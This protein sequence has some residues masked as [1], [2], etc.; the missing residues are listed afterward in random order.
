MD[1]FDPSQLDST[2]KPTQIHDFNP[3]TIDS[4]PAKGLFWTSHIATSAVQVDLDEATAVMRVDQF[5]VEDYGTLKNALLDGPSNPATVSFLM[6]WGGVRA[7]L[8]VRDL[9]EHFVS[10]RIEDTA[11]A[12]W[13]AAVPSRHFTFTSDPAATSTSVFAEIGAERNGVFFR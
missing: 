12:T 8:H 7:R 5:D 11:T 4:G 2:G 9:I 6:Q 3:G 10:D 1:L 13:S